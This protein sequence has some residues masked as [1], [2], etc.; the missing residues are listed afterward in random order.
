VDDRHFD[1]RYI[2]KILFS[3][4]NPNSTATVG[5]WGCFFNQIFFFFNSSSSSFSLQGD[6]NVVA[7]WFFNSSCSAS[8]DSNPS[9]LP[10]IYVYVY[11]F[12]ATSSKENTKILVLI[13]FCYCTYW[14]ELASTDFCI[15][16]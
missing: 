4:K 13:I 14:G 7:G 16:V 6:L 2:T 9:Y 3:N 1:Y 15:Y 8:R 11:I 5:G 10:M 12:F